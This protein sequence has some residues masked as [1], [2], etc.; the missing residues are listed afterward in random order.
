MKHNRLT[1]QTFAFLEE[2]D[3]GISFIETKKEADSWRKKLIES[4]KVCKYP[5]WNLF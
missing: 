4:S 5:N 3:K 2:L 1:Q